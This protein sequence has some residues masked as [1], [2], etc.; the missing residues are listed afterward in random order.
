MYE[1][2]GNLTFI[3][4][5]IAVTA[6]QIF[7]VIFSLIFTGKID[8]NNALSTGGMPSSHT[9]TV[10]AITTSVA[11]IDGLGST[12]FAVTLVL[13]IIVIYDAVGIRRAAG[14]H[15]EVLNEWSKILSEVYEHGFKIEDLKT[16]LGHT[17]P[18]VFAGI[19]LGCTTGFLVNYYL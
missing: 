11:I 10:A 9:A 18:Q 12:M 8:I 6:A 5:L 14:K 13:S 15:A 4:G 17:Y 1:L 2:L 3:S 7:K 19:V 16:L